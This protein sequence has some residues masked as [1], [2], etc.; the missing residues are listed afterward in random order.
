MAGV[1]SPV[2]PGGGATLG[3]DTTPRLARL[4]EELTLEPGPPGRDG[5]PSWT[6]HDPP[7]GRFFRV[8]PFEFE[9]LARWHLGAVPLITRAIE[10]ETTLRPRPEQI[11]AFA[12][13]LSGAG[14]LAAAG[15]GAIARLQQQAAAARSGGI[16]WLLKN[17]LFFRIPL[18]RP[19]RALAHLAVTLSFIFSR[20][21]LAAT[22]LAGLFGLFLAARQWDAFRASFLHFFSLEGALLALL[23][24]VLAKALHE[25]GHGLV[26]KRFGCR[27]PTM[28]IAVMVLYP[29]PYTDTSEAWRLRDRR[30]RLAVGAA[31]IGAELM[32]ACWA[33]LAWS[34]MPDGPLR[35]VAF[36]W[37]TTTWVLTVL[38][39]LSPFM[40]FD[41]YYLLSDALDVPNLQARAFALTRWRIR[42][43]LFGFGDPMPEP[44][45][46]A[47]R[48]VLIAWSIC[49]WIYRC[50]VFFGIALLVYHLAF[51]VLGL[52]L[53]AVEIW[54]FIARPI[55]AEVASW[56]ARFRDMRLNLALVR[57]L[58]GATLVIGLLAFPWRGTI[59]APALLGAERHAT[60]F[61][62]LSGRLEKIHVQVG[63]TVPEGARLF[64]LGSP[65][66]D[67]RLAQIQR[68][69]AALE[70]QVA[71]FSQDRDHVARSQILARELQA[72]RA[73]Q[74]TL[75]MERTKL[76]LAVPFAGRVVALA[77]P[78]A[79]GEW[80]RAG[81]ALAEVADLSSARV[82]AY[83]EEADLRRIAVGAAAVFVP[84]NPAL[85]RGR[86][87]LVAI[88]DLATR[89]LPDPELASVYGGPLPVRALQSGGLVPEIPV[90][91]V[92]LEP[93][94]PVDP[95][96]MLRGRVLIEGERESLAA[97]AWRQLLG[98]LVRESG[99]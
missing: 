62:T 89:L 15:P 9:I 93:L 48:R 59:E 7:S 80:V 33:L 37:A 67:H 43:A 6:L 56:V 25:L 99:F 57:T 26:A 1:L 92:R 82:E 5:A 34:L 24:L 66:L 51:K 60:V 2:A 13:F 95:H 71:T 32:L 83:I 78:L 38:V 49:T 86:L 47:M 64:Q 77:D 85:P 90:Y 41:G 87:R 97:R 81:E 21:F 17:Y 72:A 61:A 58:L 91:R 53:F 3:P 39:N 65:D 75:R 29:L 54:W 79:A 16:A 98:V 74:Q 69:I 55:T 40:R 52:L 45:S 31:G 84:E 11:E 10:R 18:V 73:E 28:G 50:V 44:W 88:D 23:A 27:V 14:L 4:R 35:S 22:L 63:E 19:D 96:P 46:A 8:G 20:R 30:Q 36:T 70:W 94:S 12:R 42:E 76:D 68:R